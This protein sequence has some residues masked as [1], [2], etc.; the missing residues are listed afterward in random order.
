MI[1]V[2]PNINSKVYLSK[3]LGSAKKAT[4]NV[5]DLST[6]T[7]LMAETPRKALP[8]GSLKEAKPVSSVKEKTSGCDNWV[9]SVD[10]CT[11]E[12]PWMLD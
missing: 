4:K 9:S 2:T 1:K 10:P 5:R 11:W 3:V 6:P 8:K 12:L 7:E